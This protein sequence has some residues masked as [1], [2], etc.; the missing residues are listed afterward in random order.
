MRILADSIERTTRELHRLEGALQKVPADDVLGPLLE[1]LRR[2]HAEHA[3]AGR[4][5]F[6]AEDNVASTQ[7]ALATIERQRDQLG[8]SLVS[9]AAQKLRMELAGATERVLQEYKDRLL[10]K[11]VQQLQGYVTECFIQLCRKHDALRRITVNP[12]DFSV[13]L[14]DRRERPIPKSQLSAGEKQ[15]YAVSML[16]A[17]ARASG[18]PL[19]MIVDTPLARLD[20]AH[21]NLLLQRYFPHASHQI[22]LLST[23]TEIDQ[24]AFLEL[25]PYLANAYR[26]EFDSTE[27]ATMMTHGYFWADRHET[28]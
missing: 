9:F 8:A 19:P 17:L 10:E 27:G 3:A 28:H 6:Q 21:R 7:T 4:D 1:E 16:W 5:A 2:L 14:W 11:K 22:V 15:I 25:K 20:S 26:L 24:A 18:R 12:K 13:T 23:D